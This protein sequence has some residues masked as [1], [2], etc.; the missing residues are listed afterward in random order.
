MKSRIQ[1]THDRLTTYLH[2]SIS[3]KYPLL[4]I[5]SFL[6]W[7]ALCTFLTLSSALTTADELH[8]RQLLSKNLTN[9]MD[10]LA[11]CLLAIFR[12]LPAGSKRL[13]A[14]LFRDSNTYLLFGDGLYLDQKDGCGGIFLMK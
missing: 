7:P 12:T 3:T 11:T 2:S 8:A 1:T 6:R 10:L 14:S 9:W 4:D 13:L 5:V